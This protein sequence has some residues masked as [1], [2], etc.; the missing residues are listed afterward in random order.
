MEQNLQKLFKSAT[1]QPEGRLSSDIWLSLEAKS[2]K[3]NQYKKI[4][5]LSLGIL[6][7]SGSVF[8]INS[9]I[10]GLKQ[11]GFFNY[12]SLI[13]SDGGLIATYWKEYTLSL[14]DSMPI[15]SLIISLF[16]LFI[17]F[18]SIERTFS[19]FKNKILI[20]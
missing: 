10:V 15:A 1:Y 13:F 20:A 9:L 3:I 14:V 8:S 17:L 19:Q 12:L 7:L 18:I 16:F 2:N 11:L 5:Y 6:S 4:G